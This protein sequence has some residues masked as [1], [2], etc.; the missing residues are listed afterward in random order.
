MQYRTLGNTDIK[1][2]LIGLGTMTFGEQNTQA[3]ADAQLDYA[4]SQGI[5]LI[6]TA[7]MYPVAPRAQTQGLTETYIGHWLKARAC[8]DQVILASKVSGPDA[9]LDYL[10][11]GPQLTRTQIE[12]ALHASLKRLQTDVIDLYQVHWPARQTNFFGKLGY[13]QGEQEQATAIEETLQALHSFVQ[14]GKIRHI[15]ISNETPWGTQAY[16]RLAEA[17]GLTRIVSIQN[18][19]NLLNRS[20]EIGMAEISHREQVGLL[21]YSPLAFGVLSGKYLGEKSPPKARLNLFTRFTRYNNTQGREASQR[22]ADIA[23][24]SGLSPAHM[25]LAFVNTRPFVTSTLIGATDLAQLKENIASIDITL[26]DELIEKIENAHQ[27]QP[28]P[29]P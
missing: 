23:H 18:P 22:Y 27:R 7:E 4:L 26:P 10:R 8:R 1:V 14:Q 11:G 17:Q 13:Q 29:C 12:Q 24:Q 2:S 9:R 6:D 20:Y 25:A 21:A 19:Y 28:N 5:N 16:L 3:Q 15:G